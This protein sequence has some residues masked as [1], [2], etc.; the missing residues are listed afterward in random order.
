MCLLT[1]IDDISRFRNEKQ[2]ASYLGLIPVS[3]SSGEKISNGEKKYSVIHRT[4]DREYIDPLIGYLIGFQR[5]FGAIQCRK[6]GNK[7]M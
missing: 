3:H 6:S 2:F 1:E 5:I 4:P 7:K